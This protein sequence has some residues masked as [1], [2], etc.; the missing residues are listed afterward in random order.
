MKLPKKM[1][2]TNDAGLKFSKAAAAGAV[3]ADAGNAPAE[4][5]G[6]PGTLQGYALKWNSLSCDRGGYVV[7]LL[8]GSATFAD[9]CFALY[10]HDYKYTLADTQSG[11]LTLT[12]DD[13]GVVATITLP[14]TQAGWD[15]AAL[16]SPQANGKAIVR[17]MSFCMEGDIK[18]E[19]TEENGQTIVNVKAFT[20]TEVTVTPIPAFADTTIG[21]ADFEDDEE[22]EA[23]DDD[24]DLEAGGLV[25]QKTLSAD[26]IKIERDRLALYSPIFLAEFQG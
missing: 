23:D 26:Y 19:E 2:F 11:T 9:P 25:L 7:R 21:P 20:C 14:D 22:M 12:P 17:G 8:P 18:A 24:E 15:T 13:V 5:D 3:Q 6:T 1:I 10:H 16:C 4:D